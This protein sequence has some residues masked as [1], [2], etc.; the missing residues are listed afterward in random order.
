MTRKFKLIIGLALV[1]LLV[2]VGPTLGQYGGQTTLPQ[3]TKTFTGKITE[4]AMGTELDILKHARFYIVRLEEYPK[5]QFRLSLEDAE[6]YGL[7][8]RGG[9]TGV[10]IPKMSK[11]IGWRVKLTC[12]PYYAGDI[13]TP[14]YRVTALERLGD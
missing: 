1:L 8:A 9:P 2:D 11:G 10:V 13:K 14:T 6:K 3:A 12:D 5:L 4:I 7:I